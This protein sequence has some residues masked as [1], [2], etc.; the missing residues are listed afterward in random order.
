[1]GNYMSSTGIGKNMRKLIILPAF[2]I[3]A[4]C[5]DVDGA[6]SAVENMGLKPTEIGG[7]AWFGCSKDD[8]YK[9]KF[10]AIRPDGKQVSGQA[11]RGFSMGAVTD[12]RRR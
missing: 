6:A 9:T 8:W 2:L 4:A 3:L 7:Y 1:M 11:C 10:K 12:L 5:T